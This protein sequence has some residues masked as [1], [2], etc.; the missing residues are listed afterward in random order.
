MSARCLCAALALVT[1][2]DAFY[3]VRGTVRSCVDQ[4]PIAGAQIRVTYPNKRG[5]ATSDGSGRY[6][7]QI[8]D[9][10]GDNTA[11]L[12]ATAPGYQRAE[13]SVR[14]SY[15]PGQDVCLQPAR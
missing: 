14:H 10:P 3:T 13:R 11:T 4:R 12:A 8:N 2:C 9:P 1:A 15:D 7:V 5:D 6:D